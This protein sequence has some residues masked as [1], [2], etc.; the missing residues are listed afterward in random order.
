LHRCAWIFAGATLVAS[1]CTAPDSAVDA[2]DPAYADGKD[3]AIS[4]ADDPKL[5]IARASR[6]LSANISV[7]DVGQ[8]F[9]TRDDSV[10]YP[11]TYW[12]FSDNGIDNK[13]TGSEVSPLEK[14]M[15]LSAP[16]KLA[17][18]RAWNQKNHGKDVSGMQSWFGMCNGWTGAS[19]S[20]K[21]VRNAVDVKLSGTKIVRCTAGSADC[22]HFEIGD[23]N[24]LLAESYLDG[25]SDFLGGRCDL[26]PADV[27]RD[28]N[29]RVTSDGCSGA[30]AGTL[31]IV[32]NNFMKKRHRGFAVNAQQP[33]STDEIWNQ[34][35]YR[36][37]I[38]RYEPLTEE[39]AAG[40]VSGNRTTDYAA[41]NADAKGWV[42]VQATF[43]WVSEDG[44]NT[45]YVDGTA[46]TQTTAFDMVIELDKAVTD[47][48]KP[49]T[50][51]I[52]GGEYLD[53]AS[54]GSDRLQ[55]FPY[56]WS[57]KGP[58]PETPAG[59]A[60]GHNPFLSPRRILQIAALAR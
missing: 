29:G 37:T 42:H 41:F 14:Y 22:V 12:P 44:P 31:L 5:L 40:L 9:G 27:K 54:L 49:G 2:E 32:A 59:D 28:A 24:G 35:A 11:D 6:R 4:A 26:K 51:N 16:T 52:V 36:Y 43:S 47:V 18:A 7:V 50:A 17:D 57:P 1:G 15:T 53:N 33:S 30:N 48:S 23:I 8:S 19:L 21:P 45:E 13:W 60:N 38:T 34:P 46:S 39:A 55:N 25:D 20:E 10:P 58:G 56:L 3:D